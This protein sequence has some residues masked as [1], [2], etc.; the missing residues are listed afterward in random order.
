MGTNPHGEPSSMINRHN[1]AVTMRVIDLTWTKLPA[2]SYLE[3]NI[4]IDTTDRFHGN[5]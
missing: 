4:G 3:C 2:W 1:Q 5:R